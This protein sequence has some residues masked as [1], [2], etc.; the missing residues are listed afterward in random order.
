MAS[1][2]DGAVTSAGASALSAAGAQRWPRQCASP[3]HG[4]GT[5]GTA[6]VS[7]GAVT[8]MTV[9]HGGSGYSS[10]P[11]ITLTGPAVGQSD[12]G[13]CTMPS[14]TQVSVT[15]ANPRANWPAN[16]WD[17]SPTGHQGVIVL[18][19]DTITDYTQFFTARIIANTA[20]A[21]GGSSTLTID[22]PAPATTYN[23]YQIYGTAGGASFVYRRYKVTNAEIAAQMT[24]H[25]P[26]PVA[27]RNSDGTAA[28]LT[29]YPAG[30]VFYSQS[31]ST[32]Y[33]QSSIGVE[34]DAQSGTI[35]AARPTA[36]VFSADGV[37]P[38]PVNDVQAFV[39]VNTGALDVRS[40]TTGYQG[41]AF[42]QLGIARTKVITCLDW[43]DSSNTL[44]MTAFASEYLA[45]VQDVVYEGSLPYFGLLAT[46][47][48]IGHKLNITGS[49]YPTGWDSFA[50]PILAIDLEYRERSGATSYI[51]TLSF[52]NRRAPFS[53]T[54]LQR[55]AVLGQPLGIGL[56]EL[57]AGPQPTVPSAADQWSPAAAAS[58]QDGATGSDSS[59]SP[60]PAAA[61]GGGPAPSD[62]L[63]G[64]LPEGSHES[65]T[66]SL[67]GQTDSAPAPLSGGATSCR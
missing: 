41:T 54:A 35:L 2:S 56:T 14:T 32:P 12:I 31:G 58:D 48:T 17:Y 52:S 33:A 60:A 27:Y 1:I 66:D 62:A 34:C 51:T 49:T 47:L 9:T 40:P 10:T 19:S 29:S 61:L 7:G 20:L 43:K 3:A 8:A 57:R 50:I 23:S 39:P 28:T 44:N 13:S 26:Y 18:R 63:A 64:S 53:G 59:D 38:A 6:C 22:S 11:T 21:A 5:R 16:Y 46:A 36:L 15:S 65:P 25:F 45:S 42:T 67:P 24:N 55:P 30:T 37:T 4:G